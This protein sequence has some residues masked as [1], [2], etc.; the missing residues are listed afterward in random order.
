MTLSANQSPV[1]TWALLL[2]AFAMSMHKM[3]IVELDA[4]FEGGLA[5]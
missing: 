5:K 3:L 4:V 2:R 1:F